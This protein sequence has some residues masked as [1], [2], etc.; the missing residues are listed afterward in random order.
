MASGA[1]TRKNV[2]VR[3]DVEEPA[4]FEFVII[5]VVGNWSES[6]FMVALAAFE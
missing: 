1:A 3:I 6:A 4:L 5:G 2:F